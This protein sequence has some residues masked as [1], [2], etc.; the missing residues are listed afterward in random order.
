MSDKTAS[1]KTEAPDKAASAPASQTQEPEPAKNATPETEAKNAPQQP[2]R[3]L[4]EA[5]LEIRSALELEPV[6]VI[7]WTK[8][9]A[10]VEENFPSE[11]L[12][13]RRMGYYLSEVIQRDGHV[14]SQKLLLRKRQ[15]WQPIT[16][17]TVVEGERFPDQAFDL[18]TGVVSVGRQ[19]LM[20]RPVEQ[21]RAYAKRCADANRSNVQ[22]IQRMRAEVAD[23]EKTGKDMPARLDEAL[24]ESAENVGK[25]SRDMEV[26]VWR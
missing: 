1:N 14:D 2:Q 23:V 24:M 5:E 20:H 8:E 9:D 13:R 3:P 22:R 4:T 19:W 17:T 12:N 25:A 6:R 15:G 16:R 18:R 10:I 7:D 11:W 26:R 21:S